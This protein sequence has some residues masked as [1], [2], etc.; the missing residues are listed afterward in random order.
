MCIRDSSI[1]APVWVTEVKADGQRLEV[2]GFTLEPAALNDWVSRLSGS[3]LMRGLRLDAV[4]VESTAAASAPAG[5]VAGVA[6]AA[7]SRES[8]AFNLVNAQ[9]QAEPTGGKP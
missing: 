3:P 6:P 5:P 8:W 7:P 9:P 2:S 4:K 1:P